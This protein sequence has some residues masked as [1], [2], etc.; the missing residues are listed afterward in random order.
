M[1][2]ITHSTPKKSYPYLAVWTG[3]E[4][5][6]DVDPKKVVMISLVK[7]E[8]SDEKVPYVQNVHGE[9]KG[10]VTKKEEDFMP[11]PKGYE[12]RLVQ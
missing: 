12:I 8:G 9:E 6:K 5:I 1:L 10:W 11:L 7:A 3:G 2:T 4:P